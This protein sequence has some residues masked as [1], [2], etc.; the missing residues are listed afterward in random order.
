[1]GSFLARVLP[2]GYMNPGP[3]NVKEHVL[4]SVIASAGGQGAYGLDNVIVQKYKAFFGH[5]EITLLESFLWV[6]ATQFVG[7]GIAGLTRRFL[8]KPKAMFFP[9]VLSQIALYTT[10]HKPDLPCGRWTMSR[11]KFFWICFAA[12]GLYTWLPNFFMSSL[13]AVSVLCMIGNISS[14]QDSP[15]GKMLRGLG[16]S[17]PNYGVG[18]FTLTFDWQ[19]I[20][21]APITTPFVYTINAIS[22]KMIYGYIL[23]PIIFYCNVFNSPD[24]RIKNPETFSDGTRMPNIN[25]L[26]LFSRQGNTIETINLLDKTNGFKL[27]QTAYDSYA[28][29]YLGDMFVL[30]YLSHFLTLSSMISSVLLWNGKTIYRQ[31]K[32]AFKQTESSFDKLDV[33]NKLMAAY[34]EIP[35]WQYMAF[36]LVNVIFFCVVTQVTPFNLPIW[37]TFFGVGICLLFILPQGII[38]AVSGTFIALNVLAQV[39]IGFLLPGETI[40]VMAFKS[41]VTNNGIQAIALIQDLKIG[42]YMKIAP[43]S[44]FG[45]QIFGTLVGSTVC[46]LVSWWMIDNSPNSSWASHLGKGLWEMT[47]YRKFTNAGAI[48]GAAGP[49][50]FFLSPESHYSTVFIGGWVIGFLLPFIPWSANK[51]YPSK[52]W[53]YISIPILVFLGGT[54]RIQNET[55]TPLIV[56]IIFQFVVLRYQK[57]WFEKYNYILAAAISAGVAVSVLICNFLGFIIDSK[58]KP[59]I[60]PPLW[61]G[62]PASMPDY[63]CFDGMKFDD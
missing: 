29:I 8:I 33:H 31:M 56:A 23:A 42:H 12:I 10:L 44:M 52:Y 30:T 38:T 35:E 37:G 7:F 19:Y 58:G 17:A 3:F 21:T 34:K 39:M 41:L 48:W 59:V 62:N 43:Y 57:D 9:G 13:T 63:Y 61:S 2:H 26:K 1:M 22:G 27:N 47:E 18:L 14:I 51:C 60:S 16:N 24:R 32:E 55:I 5:D 4:I 15:V 6:F 28:P 20:S 11:Q 45:A 40:Q 25:T 50:R 54:G 36:L 46:T 49:Y 53:K